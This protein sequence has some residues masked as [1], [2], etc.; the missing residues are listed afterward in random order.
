[1][2]NKQPELPQALFAQPGDPLPA[3]AAPARRR[4]DERATTT[5]GR[6]RF[7]TVPPARVTVSTRLLPLTDARLTLAVEAMG[8]GPQEFFE[9]IINAACDKMNIPT[10]PAQNEALAAAL[11]DSQS[12]ARIAN[13]RAKGKPTTTA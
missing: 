5:G 8:L 3:K 1:M 13:P 9:T 2:A 10:D 6:R 4:G 7:A 12:R 11:A